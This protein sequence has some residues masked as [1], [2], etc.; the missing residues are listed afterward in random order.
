[1]IKPSVLSELIKLVKEMVTEINAGDSD[2]PENLRNIQNELEFLLMKQR[3]IDED[4][5]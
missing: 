2:T 1:M 3:A 4:N 5:K